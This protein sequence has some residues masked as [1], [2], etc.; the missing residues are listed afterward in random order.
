MS[1]LSEKVNNKFNK[2]KTKKSSKRLS[3]D[4]FKSKEKKLDNL[5]IQV[6][7]NQSSNASNSLI[8][9]NDT[10]NVIR[11]NKFKFQVT[12][13]GY[14]LDMELVAFNTKV[15]VN[16]NNEN[17]IGVSQ[18]QNIKNINKTSSNSIRIDFQNN[19][20][21]I[22]I[23]SCTIQMVSMALKELHDLYT[24]ALDEVFTNVDMYR[25]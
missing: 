1:E 8:K 24:E 7:K 6:Y 20:D 23:K 10:A 18:F 2:V 22:F 17:I 12:Y 14:T 16:I 25:N 13:N 4:I 11:Q 3:N 9:T 15:Y 19:H 5:V 21:S